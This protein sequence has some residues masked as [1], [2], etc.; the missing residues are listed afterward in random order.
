MAGHARAGGNRSTGTNVWKP[1]PEEGTTSPQRALRWQAATTVEDP[2]EEED[3]DSGKTS[4]EDSRSSKSGSTTRTSGTRSSKSSKKHAKGKSKSETQE[5]G[6][7]KEPGLLEWFG[8]PLKPGIESSLGPQGSLHSFVKTGKPRPGMCNPPMNEKVRAL[9]V[10]DL[11]EWKVEPIVRS[12]KEKM[13]QEKA[14]ARSLRAEPRRKVAV[15]SSSSR[16]FTEDVSASQDQSQEGWATQSAPSLPAG[17][18]L[19]GSM[20]SSQSRVG[21]PGQARH[22][23][24][25][26]RTLSRDMRGFSPLVRKHGRK[27][28]G[29]SAWQLDDLTQEG[30]V[31]KHG[32]DSAP[33]GEV[34]WRQNKLRLMSKQHGFVL[35]QMNVEDLGDLSRNHNTYL[36]GPLQHEKPIIHPV[37][38]SRQ[39]KDIG[40][41]LGSTSH[42]LHSISDEVANDLIPRT[43]KFRLADMRG[44]SQEAPSI[45][46][47]MEMAQH[48]KSWGPNM[49]QQMCEKTNISVLTAGKLPS[50]ASYED[51]PLYSGRGGSTFTSTG[52]PLPVPQWGR[53]GNAPSLRAAVL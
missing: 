12:K 8:D 19:G 34:R 17:A 27:K 6:E 18:F 38:P 33:E 1:P 53:D 13:E 11:N 52:K 16:N 28:T 44:P 25:D 4:V 9:L 14:L 36:R 2:P 50:A 20:G 46:R 31:K 10:A 35:E 22:D 3:R 39:I 5:D 42:I 15:P 21:S 49:L 24:H 51:D 37:I 45:E 30:K 40:Q 32:L 47:L 7:P 29:E 26:R 48:S 23:R 43:R 41:E